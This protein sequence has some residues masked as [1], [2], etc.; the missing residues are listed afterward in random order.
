MKI[1]L[2]FEDIKFPVKTRHIHKIE[3]K[4]KRIGI[5]VFGYES[6]VKYPIYVSK[7]VV[8]INM[9]IYYW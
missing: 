6:K 8:K 4:K 7:N 9:L 1:L 2:N 3:K 5:S